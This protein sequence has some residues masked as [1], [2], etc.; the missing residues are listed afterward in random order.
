MINLQSTIKTLSSTSCP[1]L[2]REQPQNPGSRRL[3]GQGISIQTLAGFSYVCMGIYSIDRYDTNL[4][5]FSE[6]YGT[7]LLF[8]NGLSEFQFTLVAHCHYNCVCNR[9]IK[10]RIRHKSTLR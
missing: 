1:V 6:D 10:A 5:R 2:P 3:S 8:P 9:V 4:E 7:M